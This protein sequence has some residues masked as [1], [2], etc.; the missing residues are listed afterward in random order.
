[1]NS[2]DIQHMV[3]RG[4]LINYSSGIKF[5]RENLSYKGKTL[6]LELVMLHSILMTRV[7]KSTDMSTEFKNYLFKRFTMMEFSGNDI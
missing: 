6:Q 5:L 7:L 3:G 2:V 4:V 1:M